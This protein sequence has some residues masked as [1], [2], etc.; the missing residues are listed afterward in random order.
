[1]S[2]S[3]R[4]EASLADGQAFAFSSCHPTR[5]SVKQKSLSPSVSCSAP[6]HLI[7][8]YSIIGRWL[9]RPVG[10][11][12]DQTMTEISYALTMLASIT[13]GAADFLCGL[14][15]KCSST[16]SVV[17]ISQL[18]GLTLMLLSLPFLPPAADRGRHRLGSG[19]WL[20]RRNRRAFEYRGDANLALSGR[21][22]HPGRGRPAR[23]P[24][25]T[26]GRRGLRRAGHRT[27]RV[28]FDGSPLNVGLKTISRF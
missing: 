22:D 12:E 26:A 24:S 17:V 8:S 13:Y 3:R 21:H 20:G 28:G 19:Q 18:A 15:A 11:L 5:P 16:F 6:H 4:L 23:T 9:T 1:M 14:A 7:D 10:K 27:D 25:P 2:W